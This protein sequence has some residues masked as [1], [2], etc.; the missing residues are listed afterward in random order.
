MHCPHQKHGSMSCFPLYVMTIWLIHPVNDESFHNSVPK[1]TLN[2]YKYLWFISCSIS[3]ALVLIAWTPSH[4]PPPKAKVMFYL[5]WFV[6]LCV[7][8][9]CFFC[10]QHYGQTRERIFMKLSGKVGTWYKE[11]SGTFWGCFTKPLEHGIFSYIFAGV[12]VCDQHCGKTN[13][14]IFMKFLG[15]FRH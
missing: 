15:Y 2:G 5:C 13:E 12:C 9:F 3:F 4:Y 14:W 8:L 7:C 6:C 1:V 10:S 11:Q